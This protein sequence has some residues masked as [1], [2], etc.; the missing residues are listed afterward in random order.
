MEVSKPY[1]LGA[2][3]KGYA[4]EALKAGIDVVSLAHL[5]GHRDPS[6]ISKVYGQVQQDPEHMASLASRTKRKATGE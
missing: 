3:R 4:T 2:F 6:M 1:H 5:M